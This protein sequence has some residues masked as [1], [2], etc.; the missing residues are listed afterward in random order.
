MQA[1]TPS[2]RPL[3][4]RNQNIVFTPFTPGQVNPSPRKRQ[5]TKSARLT[6]DTPT[7]SGSQACTPSR[8]GSNPSRLEETL[9]D[10]EPDGFSTIPTPLGIRQHR[11][12][13]TNTIEPDTPIFLPNS[14]SESDTVLK[15]VNNHLQSCGWY[16]LRL[17]AA[18]A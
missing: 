14:P 5:Y 7:P 9:T 6:F 18:C 12:T 3:N 8:P 16:L 10:V 17:P 4:E 13:F 1:P 15:D 2:K 11:P